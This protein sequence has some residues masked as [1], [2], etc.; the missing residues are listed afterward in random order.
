MDRKIE[1][2]GA[3][4]ACKRD[5]E[6][7]RKLSTTNLFLLMAMLM[8]QLHTNDTQGHLVTLEST[9]PLVILHIVLKYKMF[10]MNGCIVTAKHQYIYLFLNFSVRLLSVLRDHSF[11]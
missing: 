5:K 10:N 7:H 9:H 8:L 6:L 1:L 11:F 3:I 4:I 2:N